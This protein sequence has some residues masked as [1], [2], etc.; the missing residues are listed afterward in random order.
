M[1]T[2][3][4]LVSTVIVSLKSSEIESPPAVTKPGAALTQ[5]EYLIAVRNRLFAVQEQIWLHEYAI[6]RP[7]SLHLSTYVTE[8]CLTFAPTASFNCISLL[9]VPLH[10]SLYHFIVW[11]CAYPQASIE[12][13]NS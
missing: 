4:S 12:L 9:H 11:N 8:L 5:K 1:Y 6:A 2:R 3:A 10:F 13:V 7:V